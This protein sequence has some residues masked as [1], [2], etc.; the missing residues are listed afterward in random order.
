MQTPEEF[1]RE[2]LAANVAE[3][4]RDEQSLA[5]YMQKYFLDEGYAQGIVHA[6]DVALEPAKSETIV[7]MVPLS[8][9]AQVITR[10]DNLDGQ[11]RYR[12]QPAGESWLIQRL[13]FECAECRRGQVAADCLLCGGSGWL[14]EKNQ[15]H[16]KSIWHGFK[17]IPPVVSGKRFEF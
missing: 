15:G 13:D 14:E 17:R 4:L 12:L 8:G 16:G 5:R 7:S 3:I 9:A 10:R 6:L 2:F 11:T 1:M